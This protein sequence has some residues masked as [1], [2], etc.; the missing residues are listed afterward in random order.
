MH[1]DFFLFSFAKN[2]AKNTVKWNEC[3]DHFCLRSEH[4]GNKLETF[5]VLSNN[6]CIDTWPQALT[7]PG[8]LDKAKL[9]NNV[10]IQIVLK[11][12]FC[13]NLG[14]SLVV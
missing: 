14:I 5:L 9:L 1:C 7:M 2:L 10:L 8:V 4:R 6:L 12:A 11:N 13:I 3:T